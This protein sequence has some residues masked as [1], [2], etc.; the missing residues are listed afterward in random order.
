MKNNNKK[1]MKDT[2]ELSEQQSVARSVLVLRA[3]YSTGVAGC[4]GG[5]VC[6]VAIMSSTFL[7]SAAFT[8]HVP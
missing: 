2:A 5:S 6:D 4:V 8:A 7:S 1:K 3:F